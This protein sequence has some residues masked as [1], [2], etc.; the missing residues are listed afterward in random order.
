M[1]YMAGAFCAKGIVSHVLH[2]FF[3]TKIIKYCKTCSKKTYRSFGTATSITVVAALYVAN[4]V[5]LP[6]ESSLQVTLLGVN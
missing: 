4:L 2:T 1:G 6:M 3:I 5:I